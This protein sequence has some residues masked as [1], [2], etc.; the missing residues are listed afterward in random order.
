MKSSPR[1][2]GV[3]TASPTISAKAARTKR[4]KPP[5]RESQITRSL[6]STLPHFGHRRCSKDSSTA[7]EM[8]NPGSPFTPRR[9]LVRR[10]NSQALSVSP[11]LSDIVCSIPTRHGPNCGD[12]SAVKARGSSSISKQL[13]AWLYDSRRN[14]L[15]TTELALQVESCS[16]RLLRLARPLGRVG[17]LRAFG[18]GPGRR[19]S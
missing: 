4:A 6:T 15:D 5:K 11:A 10:S 2:H 16:P 12:R 7:S 17:R 14:L 3:T 8:P 9:S 1:C 19:A 18:R 13:G